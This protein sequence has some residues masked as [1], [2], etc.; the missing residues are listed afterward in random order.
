MVVVDTESGS[1]KNRILYL[2][3]RTY[4]SG[5]PP[6]LGGRLRFFEEAPSN[7]GERPHN[8]G[9]APPYLVGLPHFFVEVPPNLGGRPHY[10]GGALAYLGGSPPFFGESP[11]K[12]GGGRCF[13]VSPIL[14]I[15]TLQHQL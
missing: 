11:P 9:G 2:Q 1:A 13:L 3:F 12:L 15:K 5:A 8:F 6:F 10:L 4:F 14:F 7:L